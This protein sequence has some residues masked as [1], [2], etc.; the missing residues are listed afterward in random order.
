[1]I[2]LL[3]SLCVFNLLYGSEQS[4]TYF[5]ATE[6]NLNDLAN[7]IHDIGIHNP[8]DLEK[9]VRLPDYCI[10]Y[11]TKE[12]IFQ[13]R[14]FVAYDEQQ[15]KI[16]GYKKLFFITETSELENIMKNEIRCAGENVR[17]IDYAHIERFNNIFKRTSL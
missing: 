5:K 13:N 4:I 8:I 1:M 9:V 11:S 12:S 16:V 7:L 15:Q 3:L 2:F 6:S 17:K 14:L 10:T